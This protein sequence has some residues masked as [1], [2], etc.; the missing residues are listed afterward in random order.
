MKKYSI[1]IFIIAILTAGIIYFG[2]KFYGGMSSSGDEAYLKKVED[3]EKCGPQPGAPGN[4]ICKNN[5]WI[6]ENAAPRTL[7][8]EYKDNKFIPSEVKIK[9]GDIVIWVNKSD[10]ITWPASGPHPTH[11][12]Y[13][14]FD[15]LRGLNT[16]ESY[17]FTFDRVGSWKYHNHLNPSATGVVLVSE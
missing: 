5:G 2:F 3:L 8:V 6:I 15:S 11:S 10:A 14:S 12:G 1:I 17:S 9:K 4:W 7:A 13:S 16:G